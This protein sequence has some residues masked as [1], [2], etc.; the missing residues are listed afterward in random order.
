M[1]TNSSG[2]GI[3]AVFV[4]THNQSPGCSVGVMLYPSTRRIR[5]SRSARRTAGPSSLRA[6]HAVFAVRRFNDSLLPRPAHPPASIHSTFR[7]LVFQNTSWICSIAASSWSACS[8]L[9]STLQAEQ[10]FAAFQNVS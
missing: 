9:T 3:A 2:W 7:F 6:L 4:S 1:T 5:G 8:V 10:S